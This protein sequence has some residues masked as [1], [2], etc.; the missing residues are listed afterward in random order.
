MARKTIVEGIRITRIGLVYIVLALVVGVAAANTG[1]NALYIVEAL[2]LAVLVLSGLASRRNVARLDVDLELP[3]D[4]H[5]N[6][7]FVAR[8]R[9][10]NRDRW[11][12]RRLIVVEGIAEGEPVLVPYLGRRAEESGE[13]KAMIKRRGVF[14]VPF[15]H[16]SSVF[17]FGFFRKGLRVRQDAAMTVF[18]EIFPA[19]PDVAGRAARIGDRAARHRGRGH[20]LFNL[21]RYQAGDERRG[22]HWKQTART[23]DLIFMEREAESGR[24]LTIVLDNAVGELSGEAELQ[25]FETLVSEAATAAHEALRQGYEVELRTRDARIPLAA[26]ATQ[27]Y[28]IMCELARVAPRPRTREPLEPAASQAPELRLAMNRPLR[29]A[30]AAG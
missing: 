11:T 27:R 8:L 1:N 12:A 23:G 25:R 13:L 2:L 9:L 24:R 10:R 16:L 5:A 4:A 3:D 14:E 21:R 26:G 28:R 20:E 30:G 6:E 22:I 29:T 7:P 17:P 18:P 15:V 19:G